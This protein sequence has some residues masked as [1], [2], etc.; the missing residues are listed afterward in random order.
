MDVEKIIFL[1]KLTWE[2]F[3]VEGKMCWNFVTKPWG[4]VA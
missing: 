1:L 2:Y 4:F 3:E